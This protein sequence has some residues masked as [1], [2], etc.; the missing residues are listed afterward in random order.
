ME[1]LSNFNHTSKNEP[2]T[3]YTYQVKSNPTSFIDSFKPDLYK[4]NPDLIFLCS[5]RGAF[6]NKNSTIPL[7]TSVNRFNG[8]KIHLWNLL[9]KLKFELF[10]IKKINKQN[11][12]IFHYGQER[13]D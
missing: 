3:I 4:E 2:L 13:K 11:N 10:G 12:K 6:I 7:K 5:K 8:L 9:T 1:N